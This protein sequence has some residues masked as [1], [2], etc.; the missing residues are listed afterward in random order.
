VG[1]NIREIVDQLGGELISDGDVHV[2]QIAPLERA[3]AHEIGFVAHAKYRKALETTKAGAVIVPPALADATT[4]PRIVI[5]DPYLYFARVA[6]L[7]NPAISP[8]R[9]VH[10]SAVVLSPLPASVNVA[11]L[12]FVGEDCVV[13]EN[14]TIGPGSVIERGSRIGADTILHAKVVVYAES[15]VGA[16][17]ILHTGCVVGSDGFGFAPKGNGSWEKIPQIGRAVIGDDVEIGANTTI[18][19]G[20]LDD[21]VIE[22]GVKL[23]NLIQIAHNCQVGENS[24]MAAFVGMAGSSKLGKRVRVGGQ[25]GIMGHIDVCDDV[26]ISAR[27]FISKSVSEKGM[28]T[29]A[30]ASQP[31]HEWLRNAVHLKHL[32]EMADRIRALEK[33]LKELESK[34]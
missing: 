9:G 34:A 5:R 29:S 21:T 1:L 12:A 6:Q 22:N 30:I 28:Y 18:D 10:P 16:R 4:L 11:P 7:L 23:D 26:V 31:H 20:A 15:V 27:S 24:A 13:G 8:Y 17:C 2:E 33:K 3:G 19:R 14:V 32:D 25:A